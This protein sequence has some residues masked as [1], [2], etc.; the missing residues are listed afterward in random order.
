MDVS[1]QEELTPK[2]LDYIS[3]GQPRRCT[4]CKI[5]LIFAFVVLLLVFIFAFLSRPKISLPV[6][7]PLETTRP[8]SPADMDQRILDLK[9][10]SSGVPIHQITDPGSK[11]H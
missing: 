8:I 6:Q 11:S 9:G 4:L 1:G 3:E 2:A 7:I 5:V 10:T